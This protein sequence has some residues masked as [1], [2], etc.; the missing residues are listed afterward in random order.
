[1][2]QP[3]AIQD[4]KRASRTLCHCCNQNL[5]RDHF[6][7]HDDLLNSQLNPLADEINAL[8]DRLT[9]ININKI[10][11]NYCEKL[12]Q[13]RID[14]HQII[15][16]FYKEK[17]E[18][19]D[20]Y[21]NESIDKQRKA[22][23]DLRSKMSELIEKQETT[24]NDINSLTFTIRTL[25][26]QMNEIEHIRIQ[27]DIRRLILDNSLIEIGRAK[28][29]PFDLSN[30]PPPH[31][32]IDRATQYDNL[33][34]SS[35]RFLLVH[36]DSSL[37]LIDEYLSI[38]K[39]N[40]WNVRDIE[41][42]CWSSTLARFVVITNTNILLIDENRCFP[43]QIKR[44]EGEKLWSCGCSNKSLYLSRNAWDSYILEYTL[45]PSIQFMT[46]WKT[47]HNLKSERRVDNIKCNNET[48]ALMINDRSSRT[49]LM[50]LRSLKTF[51][52][53]WSI[54][55]DIEYNNNVMRCCP[56]NDGEWLISDWYTSRLFHI[57]NEGKLKATVTYQS[58]P[59]GMTLFRSNILAICSN[60]GV[61]FHEL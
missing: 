33:V 53:L 54:R 10:T 44:V 57:T 23:T 56:L 51:S 8:A 17:C 16:Q 19:L 58:A 35:D 25:E 22:I 15:D 49:K 39:Q 55:L 40:K 26:R 24:K 30:L 1:M 43:E 41:D 7:E 5:C 13:W 2:S 32:T 45:L 11:K 38:V 28:I 21:A 34:T 50:E 31:L 61:N 59:N 47:T 4:C 9:A 36:N 12:N 3:C 20:R 29:V 18:E 46:A 6:N 14:C 37:C 42:M 27:V 52:P 60:A 48:L